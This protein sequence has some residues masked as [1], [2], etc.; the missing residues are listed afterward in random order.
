M[1][2]ETYKEKLKRSEF[3]ELPDS[4]AQN[5]IKRISRADYNERY[6]VNEALQH[7]WIT[8]NFED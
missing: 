4:F 1:K 7:P 6:S 2:T 5:F 3:P 8:R